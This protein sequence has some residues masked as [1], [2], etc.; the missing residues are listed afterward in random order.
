MTR[1]DPHSG[2]RTYDRHESGKFSAKEI[3]YRVVA[4]VFL[5]VVV[6]AV[7]YVVE[8]SPVVHDPEHIINLQYAEF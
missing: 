4:L 6:G 7:L 8:A 1:A 3:I 2:E 5:I